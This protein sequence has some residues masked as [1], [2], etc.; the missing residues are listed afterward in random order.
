MEEFDK[1]LGDR[2]NQLDKLRDDVAVT[3]KDLLA[4]GETP[5][6]ATARG[7]APTTSTSAS[8]TS[9]AGCAAT[10]PPASTG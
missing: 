4:V 5:G 9:R 8:S 7:P 10:A 3:N 6:A 2:P 1:V